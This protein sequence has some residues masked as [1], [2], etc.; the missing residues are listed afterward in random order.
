MAHN[1]AWQSRCEVMDGLKKSHGKIYTLLIG[2]C[3]VLTDKMKQ[4]VDRFIQPNCP[5][6]VD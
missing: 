4:D 1:N 2:Q 6:Q 5:L 3:Q